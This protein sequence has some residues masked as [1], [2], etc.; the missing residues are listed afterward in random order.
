LEGIELS[1]KDQNKLF[2]HDTA[3]VETLISREVIKQ[4]DI[5]AA[6]KIQSAWRMYKTKQWFLMISQ[7]RLQA[8]IKIQSNWRLV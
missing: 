7:L 6:I 4:R 8:A 2:E 3:Q 5:N 1:K